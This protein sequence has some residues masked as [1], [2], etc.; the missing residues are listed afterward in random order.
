M[1]CEMCGNEGAKV[2]FTGDGYKHYFE[3]VTCK[4]CF[5]IWRE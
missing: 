4:S 2:W 1:K 3:H 5:W